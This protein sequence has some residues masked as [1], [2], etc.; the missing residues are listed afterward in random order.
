MHSKRRTQIP[1]AGI[2]PAATPPPARHAPGGRKAAAPGCGTRSHGEAGPTRAQSRCCAQSR[3]EAKT[4]PGSSEG[5]TP[6]PTQLA[7]SKEIKS[8][9]GQAR[10]SPEIADSP[11]PHFSHPL[12]R[13]CPPTTRRHTHTLTLT[14]THA[15]AHTHTLTQT[16]ARAHTH[17]LAH[18]LTAHGTQKARKQQAN[19]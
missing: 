4:A 2:P 1:P 8:G 9:R 5:R 14:Q 17:T 13:R 7:D 10:C 11:F 12:P 3:R 16:H 15:R 18:S 19:K 6:R